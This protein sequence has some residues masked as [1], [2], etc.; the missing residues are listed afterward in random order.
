MDI[1]KFSIYGNTKKMAKKLLLTVLGN[2]KLGCIMTY[3][4]LMI[5]VKLCF[6]HC[7]V[8][9]Y[10]ACCGIGGVAYICKESVVGPCD[11]CRHHYNGYES[12][13]S[14]GSAVWMFFGN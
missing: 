1:L 9:T 3:N 10:E 6:N 8:P 11:K 7:M 5:P 12:L 2:I 14:S 13:E 4:G